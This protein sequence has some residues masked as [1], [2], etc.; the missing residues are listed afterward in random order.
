VLD[1]ALPPK[2]LDGIGCSLGVTLVRCSGD[3]L[4]VEVAGRRDVSSAGRIVAGKLLPLSMIRI[5]GSFEGT[6]AAR[7]AESGLLVDAIVAGAGGVLVGGEAPRVEP[8]TGFVA[9]DFVVDG[10]AEEAV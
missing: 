5:G 3:G 1:L 10:A 6:V 8:A 7:V 4:V 9:A 2:A